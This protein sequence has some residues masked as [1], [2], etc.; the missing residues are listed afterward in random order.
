MKATLL[1]IAM[2]CALPVTAMAGQCPALHAQIDKVIGVRFD[3][4]RPP[5]GSCRPRPRPFTRTAS[6]PTR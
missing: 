2:V 4:T 3:A 5:R 6:T 1:G